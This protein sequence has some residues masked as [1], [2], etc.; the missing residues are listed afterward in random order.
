[1]RKRLAAAALL[2]AACGLDVKGTGK[3]VTTTSHDPT[4]PADAGSSPGPARPSDGGG[5]PE[6]D[7]T[8]GLPCTNGVL[9]FDG[10]DDFV[11]IARDDALELPN[12]FTVEAWIKPSAKTTEMHVVSHHDTNGSA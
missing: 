9:A 6:G 3:T 11:T 8:V 1:M 12:D 10:S 7:A 2:V 5:G 4:A